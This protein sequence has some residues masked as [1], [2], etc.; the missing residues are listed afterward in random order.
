MTLKEKLNN[1]PHGEL[2]VPN[3]SITIKS[4]FQFNG[5][6]EIYAFLHGCEISKCSVKFAN[7][8]IMFDGINKLDVYTKFMMSVCMMVK[9]NSKIISDYEKFKLGVS[10]G[11]M[12]FDKVEL[13]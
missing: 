8:D 10:E 4:L 1:I 11:S 5:I 13:N 3:G 7:E 9:T 2:I 6:D 12:A